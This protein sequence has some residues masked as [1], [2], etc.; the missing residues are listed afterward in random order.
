MD[1]ELPNSLMYRR[2]LSAYLRR[3]TV[4][5]RGRHH[6]SRGVLVLDLHIIHDHGSHLVVRYN[7]AIPCFPAYSGARAATGA[8]MFNA[9]ARAAIRNDMSAAAPFSTK[10]GDNCIGFGGMRI[11][12]TR[13]G[14]RHYP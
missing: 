6:R 14:R 7:A 10:A 13:A 8:G 2:V 3:H 4:L 5:S 12:R 11:D 1:A 9:L